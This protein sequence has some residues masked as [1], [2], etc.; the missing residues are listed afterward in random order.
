MVRFICET[1]FDTADPDNPTYALSEIDWN[2][3]GRTAYRISLRK[4]LKTGEFEVYRYNYPA[5]LRANKHLNQIEVLAHSTNLLG[6]LHRLNQEITQTYPKYERVELCQHELNRKA[7]ICNYDEKRL[8]CNKCGE[9][10]FTG[11]YRENTL[12]ERHYYI[13]KCRYCGNEKVDR[14]NTLIYRAHL[15]A[16]GVNN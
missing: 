2:M 13:L 1:E 7:F 15:K 14:K 6:I 9:H 12:T 3:G 10:E 16:Q 8:T 11:H 4:N 5:A